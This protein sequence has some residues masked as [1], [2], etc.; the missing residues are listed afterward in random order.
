[1]PRRLFALLL[2]LSLCVGQQPV[3][4]APADTIRASTRLVV[5]DVVVQDRFGNP[6]RGL[7]AEDFLL[8]EEGRPENI[9]SFSFTDSAQ[10]KVA[11]SAPI[12]VPAGMAANI[13]PAGDTSP[14]TILLLDALNTPVQNQQEMG[15]KML[16]YLKKLH[17]P[18]QRMA[19]FGL[20]SDLILLQGFTTDISALQRAVEKYTNRQSAFLSPEGNA[21]E[22]PGAEDL[23]MMLDALQRLDSA[24]EAQNVQVRARTTLMALQSIARSTAGTPGRKNLIWLSSGFPITFQFDDSR[25]NGQQLNFAQS[26]KEVANQLSSSQIAVYPVD[27]SGLVGLSAYS[28]QNTGRSARGQV[29]TSAEFGGRLD[30]ERSANFDRHSTMDKIAQDTGGRAYYNRNDLDTAVSDSSRQSAVYYTLAYYPTHKEWDGKFR[31]IQVKTRRDVGK[32]RYRQGYFA[33][34]PETVLTDARAIAIQIG[35]ALIDPLPSTALSFYGRADNAA[36]AAGRRVTGVSMVEKPIPT[37]KGKEGQGLED[38]QRVWAHFLVDP[39]VVTFERTSQGLES[40]DLEFLLGIFDGNKLIGTEGTTLA[41]NFKAE[42]YERALKDGLSVDIY[43]DVPNRP[44]RARLIVRD[45]KSGKIG[46]LDQ[47]LHSRSSTAQK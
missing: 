1:M 26:L 47:S 2:L 22:A 8:T 27:A 3:A 38:L 24:I 42:S 16:D 12:S 23:P 9:A 20:S 30:A 29:M 43:I 10:P 41:T 5:V 4:P 11:S 44:L 7:K 31:K 6:V 15:R 14:L 37:A 34:R 18:A 39:R 32:L 46:S 33:T 13:P 40:C 17:N 28:A 25:M 36:P 21:M 35:T 19:V 45:N